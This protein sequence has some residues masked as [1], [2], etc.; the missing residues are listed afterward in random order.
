[1]LATVNYK[2]VLLV[3]MAA[4]EREIRDYKG[5]TRRDGTKAEQELTVVNVIGWA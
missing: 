1:M 2:S 3:L 5:N 4:R